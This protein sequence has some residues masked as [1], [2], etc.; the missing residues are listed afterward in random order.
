MAKTTPNKDLKGL[1]TDSE[2]QLK[3]TQ[4]TWEKLEILFAKIQKET[5][6]NKLSLLKDLK[7]EITAAENVFESHREPLNSIDES[8][9]LKPPP[10]N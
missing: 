3:R 9:F 6:S 8:Q 10:Q 4:Q 1:L 2:E 7:A 5:G